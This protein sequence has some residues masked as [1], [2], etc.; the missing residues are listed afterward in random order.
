MIKVNLLKNLGAA[1]EPSGGTKIFKD[2]SITPQM[3]NLAAMKLLMILSV[4]VCLYIFEKY[5][6]DILTKQT[7]TLNSELNKINS[8]IQTFGD[9]GPK[10]DKYSTIK[11][12][13]DK[14]YSALQLIAE[15]RLQEVK[16]LDTIQSL[17]PTKNWIS[18]ID[19]ET[20]KISITGFAETPDAAFDFV[21]A[22][23]DNPNF[24]NVS[25]VVINTEDSSSKKNEVAAKKYSFEFFIGKK[26]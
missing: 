10:V 20:N 19:I 2:A 23:E 24:Y 8:E 21:K 3:K 18:S 22:V 25:K 1:G 12:K 6:L 17:V 5:N 7:A 9:T 16:T 11:A 13:L 4:P 15:K 14:Q 26:P